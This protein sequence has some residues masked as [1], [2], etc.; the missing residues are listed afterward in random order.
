MFSVG[1]DTLDDDVMES[2]LSLPQ[3]KHLSCKGFELEDSYCHRT[4]PWTHLQVSMIGVL[5]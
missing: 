5:S 2:L 1:N 3:L 4:C